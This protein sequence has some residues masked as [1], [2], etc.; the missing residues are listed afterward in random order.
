MGDDGVVQAGRDH[1]AR[2]YGFVPDYA[3]LNVDDMLT[4]AQDARDTV[5]AYRGMGFDRLLST[6]PWQP[7]ITSTVWLTPSCEAGGHSN[8]SRCCST[9][10][11]TVCAGWPVTVST[12]W[13][14][15]L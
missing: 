10:C 11:R 4:S 12:S 2:Y 6:P 3:R 9:N 7:S 1:L 15:R 5:R 13:V 14:D 8:R